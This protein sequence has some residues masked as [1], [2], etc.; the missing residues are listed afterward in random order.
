MESY[1]MTTSSLIFLEPRM[2]WPPDSARRRRG[3]ASGCPGTPPRARST[4]GWTRTRRPR[5][6]KAPAPRGARRPTPRSRCAARGGRARRWRG[7]GASSRRRCAT[8]AEKSH[9]E[10]VGVGRVVRAGLAGLAGLMGFV[11]PVK[12]VGIAELAGLPGLAVLAGL[13]GA[14]GRNGRGRVPDASHTIEFEETDAS[15][16]RPQPF[17]PGPA[18]SPG[19]LGPV[20]QAG[21]GGHPPLNT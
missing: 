18:G 15:R 14:P 4:S 1:G 20:S 2:I 16:T 12:L 7:G 10:G 6:A 8:P 9:L 19:A 11:V 5:P 21:R 17:L 13:V 3:A